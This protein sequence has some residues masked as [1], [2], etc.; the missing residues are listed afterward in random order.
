MH[1]PL[2][3]SRCH[4]NHRSSRRSLRRSKSNLNR[5][6]LTSQDM[7]PSNDSFPG[8]KTPIKTEDGISMGMLPMRPWGNSYTDGSMPR[9]LY[10]SVSALPDDQSSST[11]GQ[12][13]SSGRTVDDG[14]WVLGIATQSLIRDRILQY[15]LSFTAYSL[16]H[17]LDIFVTRICSGLDCIGF[18]ERH[19]F[20]RPS[21]NSLS[22]VQDY[23]VCGL[24]G[25]MHKTY[26]LA[27]VLVTSL[28]QNQELHSKSYLI[29]DRKLHMCDNSG[30]RVV[31]ADRF[32][33]PW[34]EASR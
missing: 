16:K 1:Q 19:V 10:P 26:V 4:F 17:A 13:I 24:F 31:V 33:Y 9:V 18:A 7:S 5:A 2:T 28:C 6:L 23:R 30:S 22:D 15:I 8:D 29:Q 32:G 11:L 21:R 3:A 14:G 25:P 27:L 20:S 12:R 34:N